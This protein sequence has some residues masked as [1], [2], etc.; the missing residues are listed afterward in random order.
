MK[1][2]SGFYY[3]HLPHPPRHSITLSMKGTSGFDHAHLSHPPGESMI[4]APLKCHPPP[5]KWHPYIPNGFLTV[6]HRSYVK[7]HTLAKDPKPFPHTLKNRLPSRKTVSRLTPRAI[8]FTPIGCMSRHSSHMS[9]RTP[10]V[11]A[12]V[13]E[14]SL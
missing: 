8:P 3:A 13:G 14:P 1:V 12:H 6:P 7:V 10:Y 2:T 11:K 9:K 5:R 4:V